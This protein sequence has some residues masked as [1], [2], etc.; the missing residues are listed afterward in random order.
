MSADPT[1]DVPLASMRACAALAPASK[2]TP[3]HAQ[4]EARDRR[5][6]EMEGIA[7]VRVSKQLLVDMAGS[8]DSEPIIVMGIEPRE[9]GSFEML[10][11]RPSRQELQASIMERFRHG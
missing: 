1:P 2:I 5:I 6:A 4:Y 3:H 8:G 7:Y 11:R 9:D 10:L